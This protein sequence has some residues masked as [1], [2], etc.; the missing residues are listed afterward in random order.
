MKE[1]YSWAMTNHPGKFIG[2]SIGFLVGVFIITLGFWR[3]LVLAFFVV[4]GFIIGK[5]QDDHQIIET[6]YGK[7]SK[8]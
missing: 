2:V 1:L 3:T 4:M 7:I 6:W 5:L 8:R